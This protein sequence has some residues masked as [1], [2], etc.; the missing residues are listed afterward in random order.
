MQRGLIVEVWDK[1]LLWD[2]LLGS[3]WIPLTSVGPAAQEGPGA[4][5]PLNTDVLMEGSEICGVEN[6]TLHEILLDVYYELPAGGLCIQHTPFMGYFYHNMCN[7]SFLNKSLIFWLQTV[8]CVLSTLEIIN[9][10]VLNHFDTSLL[11]MVNMICGLC[12]GNEIIRRVM[13]KPVR[14]IHY[15]IM[16][17]KVRDCSIGNELCLLM[18]LMESYKKPSYFQH[19]YS[20]FTLIL[21]KGKLCFRI[22]AFKKSPDETILILVLQLLGLNTHYCCQNCAVVFNLVPAR[23]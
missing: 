22:E 7:W 17:Y 18:L 5:W 12:V 8:N 23:S 3:V 9:F 16:E 15:C 19:I 6:P 20:T 1:R 4:W 10:C 13:E 11:S 21:H 14:I 2:S